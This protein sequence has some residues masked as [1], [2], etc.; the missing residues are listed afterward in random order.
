M[1][2]LAFHGTTDGVL[3]TLFVFL[4]VIVIV[5]Y[6]SLME[7]PYHQKLATLYLQP[8][9]RILVLLI[10][11]FAALWCPC[12]GILVAFIV[13]LYLND[14]NTLITPFPHLA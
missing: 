2:W 12:V 11:L 1:S 4:G 14:M 8:W 5:Y 6:S 13:F 9:W 3:R 7:R 10:V